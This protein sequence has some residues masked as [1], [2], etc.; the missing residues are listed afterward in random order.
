LST[1]CGSES[2][3]AP[4]LLVTAHSTS[5]DAEYSL[6]S[7]SRAPSDAHGTRSQHRGHTTKQPRARTPGTYGG[8]KTDAWALGVVLFALAMR[9]LPF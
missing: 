2:Y 8:R 6:P 7:L 1:R 5:T 4:E 9:A 3:A